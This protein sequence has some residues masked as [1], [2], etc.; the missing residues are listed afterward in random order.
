MQD[1]FYRG[2]TPAELADVKNFNFDH[3]GAQN[4]CQDSAHL[5]LTWWSPQ[6]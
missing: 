5:V 6:R 4:T 2:L 3:P 1:S